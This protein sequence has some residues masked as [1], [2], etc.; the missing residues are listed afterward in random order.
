MAIIVA[1]FFPARFRSAD[2]RS[3]RAVNRSRNHRTQ[4]VLGVRLDG[5]D[6]QIEFVGAVDFPRHAVILGR[7]EDVGFSEV[8]QPVN[9]ARRVI[10]HDEHGTGAVFGPREK[11]QM[12]GAEVEHRWEQEREPG[13]LPPH[14]QRR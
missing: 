4:L 5:L 12:I 10:F 14:R 11:E 9:A 8:V 6:H 2:R 7:R 3:S 13:W 1:S